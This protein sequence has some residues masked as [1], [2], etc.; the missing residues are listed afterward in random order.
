MGS[1]ALYSPLPRE[2]KNSPHSGGTARR[3]SGLPALSAW[4]ASEHVDHVAGLAHAGEQ[5]QIQLRCT[6]P[7]I[8]VP[9][10]GQHPHSAA[11]L[12]GH[13]PAGGISQ[14]L[15][16]PNGAGRALPGQSEAFSAL[17]K[18]W[19]AGWHPPNEASGGN[20]LKVIVDLCVGCSILS[21]PLSCEHVFI[22][23]SMHP[24]IRQ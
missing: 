16:L 22:D 15:G 1:P 8:T 4:A 6:L 23:T 2:Q 21:Y 12:H 9:F 5:G 11:V 24:Y 18:R 7:L 14:T 13:G 10:I 3:T 17:R 19:P 20:S